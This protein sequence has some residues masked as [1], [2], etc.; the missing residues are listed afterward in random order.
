M[1]NQPTVLSSFY[2]KPTAVKVAIIAVLLIMTIAAISA[3]F[4]VSNPILFPRLFS[5][6]INQG[7]NEYRVEPE[8]FVPDSNF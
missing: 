7:K 4:A 3:V 2:E 1:F 6:F 8:S 5:E